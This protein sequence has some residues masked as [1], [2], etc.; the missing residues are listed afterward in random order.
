MKR[1]IKRNPG[2]T[3]TLEAY[4]SCGCGCAGTCQC[5]VGQVNNNS[6]LYSARYTQFYSSFLTIYMV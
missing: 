1:L 2:M 4:C 3:E 6:A 5:T